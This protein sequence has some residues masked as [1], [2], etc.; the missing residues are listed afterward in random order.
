MTKCADACFAGV[1][2]SKKQKGQVLFPIP[3]PFVFMESLPPPPAGKID[4]E[5]PPAPGESDGAPG[6]GAVAPH[7]LMETKMAGIR[8]I[9]GDVVDS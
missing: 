7:D 9:L 4:L 6:I 8:S 2:H 1:R 5:A 3:A